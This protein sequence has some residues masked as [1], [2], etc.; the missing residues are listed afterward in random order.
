MPNFFSP[1]SFSWGNSKNK[2]LPPKEQWESPFCF[3]DVT[4]LCFCGILWMIR[5]CIRIMS[6]QSTQGLRA[7]NSYSYTVAVPRSIRDQYF[8]RINPNPRDI[9]LFETVASPQ[10]CR[11]EF[12]LWPCPAMTRRRIP[13]GAGADF[14][15]SSG[16]GGTVGVDS[17]VR[18][19]FHWGEVRSYRECLK[20]CSGWNII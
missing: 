12:H 13:T 17:P 20:N 10:C 15:H 5:K 18:K 7:F 11:S 3:L 2:Q 19:V 14:F 4:G 9:F 6:Q 8:W 16:F 1:L